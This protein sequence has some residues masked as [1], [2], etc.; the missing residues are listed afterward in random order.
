MFSIVLARLRSAHQE[1]VLAVSRDAV[2]RRAE[3]RVVGHLGGPLALGHPRPED[4]LADVLDLDRPG[5]VREVGER[6]LHRDQPVEQV[7]LVVLEADVQDVGLAARRDV[8]RHLERH[9]RLAGALRA[10]DQQQLP[11]AQPAPDGLV[12]RGEP[13]R[14]GLVFGDVAGRD[15][16]VEVDEHVE[17]RARHE[18]AGVG[19]EPPGGRLRSAQAARRL[20]GVSGASVATGQTPP[21]MGAVA[22]G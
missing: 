17:R 16:V 5:L 3:A 14:D 10:A 8:A 11:G 13:E 15:L 6:R 4:L 12:E 7:L 2:H 9:R 1:Q 21:R 20:A 18:A 22:V 19:I